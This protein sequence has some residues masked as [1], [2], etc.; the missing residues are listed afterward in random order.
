MFQMLQFPY[1]VLKNFLSL[2]GLYRESAPLTALE[3]GPWAL[4]TGATDRI[5]KEYAEQLA[6][7][8][9]N[10]VLVSRTPSKLGQLATELN[11]K[12]GVQSPN[13]CCGFQRRGGN[14]PENSAGD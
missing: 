8:G 10:I 6:A 5:R 12:Y 4:V 13:N 3:L 14:L 7:T 9:V 11:S 1:T 2:F